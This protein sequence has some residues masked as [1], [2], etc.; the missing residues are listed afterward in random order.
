MLNSNFVIVGVVIAL[1]GGMGY[2][3]D[4]L[5]GKAK[6]NRV[7]FLLWAI[8]TFIAFFAQIKQGV[9]V[10]ALLT[11]SGGLIAL[12]TFIAS[13]LNK[14]AYWKI[15]SFDIACGIFS[16]L[17]LILWQITKVGNTAIALSIVADILAAIPTLVKSHR[18]PHT[19]NA[20]AYLACTIA[21]VLTILTIT[22]WSFENYAWPFYTLS[23]NSLI[24]I[25]ITARP[26]VK[27]R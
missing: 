26:R 8:S 20:P 10:Q 21:A 1:I 17:A 23:I 5:N 14:K 16:A 13:F 3:I 25:L 12:M 24:Y 6:P 9:G 18:Y 2:V 15:T 19:E 22:H 7:T 4:T 11:L 27:R